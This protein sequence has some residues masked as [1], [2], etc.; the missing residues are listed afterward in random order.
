MGKLLIQLI[1]QNKEQQDQIKAMDLM[2]KEV[3][4]QQTSIVIKLHDTETELLWQS[5]CKGK[6]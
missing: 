6:D 4:E 2:L 3:F 5:R 1:A